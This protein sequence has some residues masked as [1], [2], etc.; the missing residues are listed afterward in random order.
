MAAQGSHMEQ[1]SAPEAAPAT[2]APSTGKGMWIGL[3]VVVIV[4][5]ILLAAVFGGLLGPPE[6]RVLKIGT[7]LSITGGLA[8][9][10]GKNRQGV[11]MAIDEINAK[12]GV[13]GAPVQLFHQNDATNPDTAQ[14]AANTL[15]SQN[16]V[17]AII[18]ATGSGQCAR[19][20]TVAS[21]NGVFEISGSCTSPR[22]TNLTLTGGWW[23]R[24][25]P[26][27]ALQGVVAASYAHSNLSYA[28]SAVIGINN[29]YGVALANVY[30]GNFTRLGG[31]VTAGSPRIVTE[32]QNG[33]TDY[34]TDLTAVLDVTPAPQVVYLVAYP[35]DAILVM[36][37]WEA[38][39]STHSAGWQNVF[40]LFSEGVFDQAGFLNVLRNPPNSFNISSYEGTAPSAFGGITGPNYTSW[41]SSYNTKWG[42]APGLFDDNNYDAAYLIA[43]AAQAAGSATGAAIKSKIFAVA[44]PPGT[45]IYPGQWDKAL[46]E[47]AAGRDINYEGSSGAV[48]IDTYGDPLSGYIVWA[49]NGAGTA[50]NKEIYP[51]ALVVSLLPAPPAPAPPTRSAFLGQIQA[52]DEQR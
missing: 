47:I 7:V 36:Q 31:T 45:T 11:I 16:R 26:S 17:D 14:A 37:N 39:K 27:D 24:T 51:E 25:A 13:L 41:Q 35:P 19:V 21:A 10:G 6:D 44:N 9:F 46:V 40:W 22:F 20:V 42:A 23:A 33:A 2:K 5:V 52:R 12:G 28:R 3:I 38:G 4:I 50:Y 8:A 32:V 1:Q 18:G 29:A 49:V 48:N 30:A 43:L 34:T 15:V